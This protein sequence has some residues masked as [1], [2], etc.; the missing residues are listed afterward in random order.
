MIGRIKTVQDSHFIMMLHVMTEVVVD[1]L[2]L[3]HLLLLLLHL[4]MRLR[5]VHA[6]GAQEVGALPEE[7]GHLHLA[8][9]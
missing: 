4:V 5:R 3:L 6:G 9:L 2:L 7:R 1:G 8:A